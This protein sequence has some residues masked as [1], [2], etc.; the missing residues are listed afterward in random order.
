M[1]TG[2]ARENVADLI[3]NIIASAGV[4]IGAAQKV[5]QEKKE[6]WVPLGKLKKSLRKVYY[7]RTFENSRSSW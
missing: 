6:L 7:S 3:M 4:Q 5:V 1:T 2:G